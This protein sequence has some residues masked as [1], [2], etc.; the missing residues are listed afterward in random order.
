MLE[1]KKGNNIF[2]FLGHGKRKKPIITKCQ[3][4]YVQ[5]IAGSILNSI[6]PTLNITRNSSNLSSKEKKVSP[7]DVLSNEPM[8]DGKLEEIIEREV[9]NNEYQSSVTSE[10]SSSEHDYEEEKRFTSKK[11]SR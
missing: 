11:P 4:L 7:K 3:S 8:P 5:P 10:E 6:N 9:E 2:N 1:I